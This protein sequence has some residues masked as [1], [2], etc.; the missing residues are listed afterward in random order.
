MNP[1]QF[2]IAGANPALSHDA[3]ARITANGYAV[4]DRHGGIGVVSDT[5]QGERPKIK[6]VS[7]ATMFGMKQGTPNA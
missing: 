6:G 4:T 7:L 5:H 1:K 2:I 3:I